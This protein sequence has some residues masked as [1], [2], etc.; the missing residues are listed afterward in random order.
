MNE[1]SENTHTLSFMTSPKRKIFM[2][3]SLKVAINMIPVHLLKDILIKRILLSVHFCPVALVCV[4]RINV[5]KIIRD[6]QKY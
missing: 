5:V 2:S 3:Y 6:V 1:G 4:H